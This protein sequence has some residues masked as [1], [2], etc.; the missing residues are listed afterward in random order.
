MRR[1]QYIDRAQFY[2][3][4]MDNP[5]NEMFHRL[6]RRNRGNRNKDSMCIM[7]N[8][9]LQYSATDQ[10]QSFSKYF[11][12]LALPKD[13]GYDQD[14]LDLCNVRHKI[15]QQLCEQENITT[16]FSTQNI[17]DA[18]KQLHSGKATDELGLAAE[19]FKNSPEIVTQFLTDCFNTIMK[20]KLIPHIFKSGIVIPVLKKGKN[21]M[22]MDNYRGIAITPVVSKLFECTILPSLTQNFKL[23]TLQ[24]GCTK[25]MSML[26]AGLLSL[27]P[28]QNL[29]LKIGTTYVGCP[30]CADDVAFISKCEQELQCML[31]V[32]NHHANQY[33]VT[34]N[35]SK[36]K[37]VILNKP[38]NVNRSDLQW[39][40]GNNSIYPSEDITHLGL[41]RAEIKENEVN[42]EA[43]ISIA[44]RTLY[45]L[46]NTGLHGTNG[47]NLQ[48]SYK[49]Y[50]SYVIPRLLYGMQILPL[51]QKQ[52]DILS[53]FHKKTLRNF[54]SMPAR[55][56]TGAVYLILGALTIEAEIHKRQLSFLYNIVSC[57]NSTIQDL[58][59]RQ[60]IMNLDNQHSFFCKVAEIESKTT[61]VH[62]DRALLK[63][64]SVHP[65]WTSLSSTISDVKKGAIKIRLLTGTYLFE[66]NKHKF[67]GGKESSL[68]RC[69][70]TSN[71][72]ITHFLLLCP[73]LHQQRKET[74][75]YLKALVISIIGTSGWTAR[76]KN[77]SDVVKLIID[78]TFLL[79][80]INSHTD[81]DKIQKMSTDMC[82]R[83]H[84]QR[85][86]I[87]QKS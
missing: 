30:T 35:P 17:S 5:S 66:S 11:E 65:V 87:L 71:E 43:R 46:M 14:F 59:D 48:T 13:K 58:V 57:D 75:S 73:A 86:C 3:E 50:Q 12:D 53:R 20:D 41:I 82:Y 42:I 23:S 47:L 76:F 55:T 83:L 61:L 31:S 45:S 4:V 9:E 51:N 85:T 15:I 84:T 39:T 27:R 70:G 25:G 21:P 77:Q 52:L 44:R 8:G 28:E 80:E 26:M 79:P 81:L 16:E 54:Q 32:T 10:T 78:S 63:I 68:C 60:L 56:A 72:D 1:E 64:G 40:L 24:F 69:C 67:S 2:K 36:T 34:I 38:K 37:A 18:I 6:I 33:R 7:E 22:M 19:H 74:F 29:G 62:L 49:I